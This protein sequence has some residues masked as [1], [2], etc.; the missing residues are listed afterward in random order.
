MI[1]VKVSIKGAGAQVD[2][3]QFTGYPGN[4]LGDCRFHVNE[5]V[6]SADVWLVIEGPANESERCEVLSGAVAHLT[7][8]V[9]RPVGYLSEA[10]GLRAFMAQFDQF[11][12]CLDFA[13]PNGRA[14]LPF[15]PWMVNANHGPSVFSA[16]KRDYPYLS[17]LTE[18]PKTRELSVFCSVQNST[19]EHRLRLRFVQSLADH[20]GN[21]LDWF[22]N[23]HRSVA[24][25]WD[26]IAPYRYS[27]AL[28]NQASTNVITEKIQDVYLG[29]AYPIY[30][31]AP[32]IG[33]YFPPGSFLAIDIRDPISAIG[34]IDRLL[35]EDPYEDLHASI[36]QGKNLV[37]DDLNF[38]RRMA[39]I[40]GEI[41]ANSQGSARV[42]TKVESVNSIVAHSSRDWVAS[43]LE[44][45]SRRLA[46]LARK[47][48]SG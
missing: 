44:R 18:V 29:L 39:L 36:L 5:D 6:E 35:V 42:S 3:S 24:E 25:K 13:Q 19:P 45:S 17:A 33:D 46:R 47:C 37:L 48:E 41:Y 28:E 43:R 40:A 26:G 34:A 27:L 1:E 20:F 4:V 23:G 14:A 11:Y 38:V 8:E 21:R 9:A 31:G 15:L 2:L 12:T 22:G 30:W 16:H 7:A 32:N 10:P